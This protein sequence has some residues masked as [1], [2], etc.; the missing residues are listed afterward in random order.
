MDR[1]AAPSA[2][3]HNSRRWVTRVVALAFLSGSVFVLMAG[4]AAAL[5]IDDPIG[6][7]TDVV[8][9]VGGVVTDTVEPVVENVTETVEPVVENVTETVEPV[10]DEVTEAVK[11]VVDEAS[12]AVKPV[13]DEVTE[14]VK[15][16]VDEVTGAVGPIVDE[17][18]ENIDDVRD[19]VE[20]IVGDVTDTVSDVVDP[21]VDVVEPI[22]DDAP[23]AIGEVVDPVLHDTPD[24]I[25]DDTGTIPG[26][27]PPSDD[28]IVAPPPPA[29]QDETDPAERGGVS[30]LLGHGDPTASDLAVGVGLTDSMLIDASMSGSSTAFGD[31][32]SRRGTSSADPTVGT[33][34]GGVDPGGAFGIAALLAIL[35]L[36]TRLLLPRLRSTTAPRVPALRSAAL[37][38]SVERPG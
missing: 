37:A 24:V 30:V 5:D 13:V 36:S 26:D 2:E 16:V 3:A 8:D 9:D 19:A 34:F 17:V 38:L 18:I 4:T 28:V 21:I 35:A 32:S 6:D 11:P 23:G 1:E 14:A 27:T 7:V 10:V 20:P 31:L 12:E 22:V 25:R 33:P 29:S 15:P